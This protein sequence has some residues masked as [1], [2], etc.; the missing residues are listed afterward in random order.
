MTWHVL[1]PQAM[2]VGYT[3]HKL[4]VLVAVFRGKWLA[5]RSCMLMVQVRAMRAQ[6]MTMKVCSLA[7]ICRYLPGGEPPSTLSFALGETCKK[8]MPGLYT[9]T[10]NKHF[11]GSL[12]AQQRDKHPEYFQ[13]DRH[14]GHAGCKVH[15]T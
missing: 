2:T 14:F 8:Q 1:Q 11:Y 9:E 4:R 5:A 10:T 7:S 6:A 3:C 15:L 12:P 13:T